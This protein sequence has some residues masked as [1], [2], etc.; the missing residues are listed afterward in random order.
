MDENLKPQETNTTPED[1]GD[2][3]MSSVSPN[4]FAL[5][6]ADSSTAGNATTNG[7]GSNGAQ[8]FKFC[9]RC[10]RRL[11]IDAAYCDGCGHAVNAKKSG[12]EFSFVPKKNY[13]PEKISDI[14]GRER[15]YYNRKFAELKDSD[16]HV[17]WNWFACLGWNWYAYRKMP[18][19]A[20][21]CFVSFML[22]GL[23]GA[24][25]GILQIALLLASGA[26]GNYIYLKHIHHTID[27]I[28]ALP[29]AMRESA[30]KEYGGVS[31][32]ML[33]AAYLVSCFIAGGVGMLGKI[34]IGGPF[35]PL[36]GIIRGI[37]RA[38]LRF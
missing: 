31:G 25:G 38:F 36:R 2:G 14:I 15:D 5:D 7:P 27:R 11:V 24:V 30:V 19:E 23:F 22:L 34:I 18:L 4:A 6:E 17:C 33:V 28:D 12:P 20:A 29:A 8:A 10:G 32:L 21:V 13:I 26:F 37:Y 16:S 3:S 35:T 9:I 1:T